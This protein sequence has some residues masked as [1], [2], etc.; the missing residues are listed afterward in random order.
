[1]KRMYRHFLF[2]V[3]GLLLAAC[4]GEGVSLSGQQFQALIDQGFQSPRIITMSLPAS[5]RAQIYLETPQVTFF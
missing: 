5:A 1:M 4:T 3:C 2:C